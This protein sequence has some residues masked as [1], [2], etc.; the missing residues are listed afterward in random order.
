MTL[1]Y[2]VAGKRYVGGRIGYHGAEGGTLAESESLA[3]LFAEGNE[4]TVYYD[5]KNP[6]RAILQPGTSP[7]L[8]MAMLIGAGLLVFGIALLF[9]NQAEPA[10]P[11]V[12][13]SSPFRPYAPSRCCPC[14][15]GP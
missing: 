12:K 4:V 15:P 5:P 6:R 14:C 9:R 8:L 1:S 7:L 11:G 10:R 2:E 13:P 3:R